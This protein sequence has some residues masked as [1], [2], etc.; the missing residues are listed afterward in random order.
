M[1]LLNIGCGA[2]RPGPPWINID[3]LFEVLAG[4]SKD[5]IVTFTVALAML[6]AETNYV[7]VDLQKSPL[8]FANDSV[9]GIVANH[10]LEHFDCLSALKLLCECK[11]V[12]APGGVLR[13]GVPDASIFR[14]N[15]DRDV[16]GGTN[17]IYGEN[18]DPQT[19]FIHAAL[20]FREHKQ[21][22]TEDSLWC[23]FAETGFKEIERRTFQSS[24]LSPLA[25]FD[26]RQSFTLFMEGVK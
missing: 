2:T 26:N 21:V 25:D 8:P 7:N 14:A 20:F 18:G 24:K 16:P 19:S 15:F 10:T 3:N 13:I 23:H 11:R 9:N 5:G 1:T 22:F 6:R 4:P 17:E 12:L